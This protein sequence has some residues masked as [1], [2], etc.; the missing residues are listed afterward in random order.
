MPLDPYTNYIET[1]VLRIAFAWQMMMYEELGVTIVG[2]G[3]IN[4]SSL[5]SGNLN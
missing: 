1:I 5:T 3:F 2:V 4:S